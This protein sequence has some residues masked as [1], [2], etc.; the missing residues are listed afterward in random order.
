MSQVFVFF[1]TS[2]LSRVCLIGRS[3]FCLIDSSILKT[4][5]LVAG[6][7]GLEARPSESSASKDRRFADFGEMFIFISKQVKL[8]TPNLLF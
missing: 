8:V 6:L 5:G 4:V 2:C 7:V 3:E 1:F